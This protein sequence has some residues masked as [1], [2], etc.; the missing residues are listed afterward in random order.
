METKQKNIAKIY[1]FFVEKVVI[2]EREK[3][4]IEM[5]RKTRSIEFEIGLRDMLNA[6]E[7]D[8]VIK[9]LRKYNVV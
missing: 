4:I 5:M 3:I 9:I 1:I 7:F 6:G 8:E 2:P